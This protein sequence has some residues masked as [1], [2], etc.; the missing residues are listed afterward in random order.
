MA[1]L[2]VLPIGNS[3]WIPCIPIFV[4]EEEEREAVEGE[5]GMEGEG[6]GE[7]KRQ[8]EWKGGR[9]GCEGK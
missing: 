8:K 4:R 9:E 2:V 3:I 5:G 7:R 1:V 6:E